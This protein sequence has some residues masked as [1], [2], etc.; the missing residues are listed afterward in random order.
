MS[1][2]TMALFTKTKALIDK[3]AALFCVFISFDYLCS[4][5]K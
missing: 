5:N 4:L 1:V 2:K 3:S